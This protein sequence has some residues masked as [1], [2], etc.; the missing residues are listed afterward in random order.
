L[1]QNKIIILLVLNELLSVMIF[2]TSMSSQHPSQLD[3]S[4]RSSMDN[5]VDKAIHD[6]FYFCHQKDA[7]CTIKFL[8]SIITKFRFIAI[9]DFLI[10]LFK[11]SHI[12]TGFR[13]FTLFHTFT[14]IPVNESSLSIHKIEFMI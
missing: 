14:D 2:R 10:F 5:R 9:T 8:I 6:W 4:I 1:L 3:K 11:S 12:F 13:E 7:E